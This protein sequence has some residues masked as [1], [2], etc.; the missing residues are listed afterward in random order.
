M[1]HYHVPFA[2]RGPGDWGDMAQDL[3][4]L[5]LVQA[6]TLDLRVAALLWLGMERRASVIVAALPRLAGKT[7]LLS[8]LRDLLP[9][10]VEVVYT[11]GQREDFSFVAHT[12][13][14]RTYVLC[15]EISPHLP[16]YLWGN[17]VRVLFETLARGY[18]LGATMHAD[19]PEEVVAA[20]EGPPL[21][22]PA[23]AMARV[24]FIVNLYAEDGPAGVVRRVSQV[25]LAAPSHGADPYRLLPVAWW[26]PTSDTFA[27]A[28]SPDAAQALEARLG[29]PQSLGHEMVRREGLL[30]RWLAD[31]GTGPVEMRRQVLAHYNGEKAKEC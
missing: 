3:S 19:S 15:N 9:P 1:R 12:D 8:A 5:Q 28:Q 11:R 16:T 25:T 27:W 10:G 18:A 13:P 14:G 26:E 29:F 30:A 31:E 4:L 6:G 22:V 17:R 7:T 23:E 24:T 2:W 21:L 20:L